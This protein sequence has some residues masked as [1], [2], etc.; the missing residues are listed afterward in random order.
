MNPQNVKQKVV[1]GVV[2]GFRGKDK[3]YFKTILD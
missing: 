1:V 2:S 3:F